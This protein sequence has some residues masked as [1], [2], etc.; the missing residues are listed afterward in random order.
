M[1]RAPR[2]CIA[3]LMSSAGV[4]VGIPSHEEGLVPDDPEDAGLELG[5][6]LR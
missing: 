6:V 5:N 1:K 4:P 3:S 2:V